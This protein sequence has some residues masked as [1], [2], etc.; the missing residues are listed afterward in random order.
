MGDPDFYRPISLL[1]TSYK[2]YTTLIDLRARRGLAKNIAP[3][4]YGFRAGMSWESAVF[5][6]LRVEE[7]ANKYPDLKAYLLLLDWAKAYDRFHLEPT[8]VALRRFG[9]SDFY[10]ARLKLIFRNKR[11]FERPP[12][13]SEPATLLPQTPSDDDWAIEDVDG[14]RILL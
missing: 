3:S 9:F 6:L 10:V 5:P 2:L 11:F 1:Q 14:G 4:Q 13:T 12:T 8:M 7:L